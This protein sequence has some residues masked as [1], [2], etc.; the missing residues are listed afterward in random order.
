MLPVEE[1][2]ERAVITDILQEDFFVHT[3]IP[4][5]R[6]IDCGL[7]L[8]EIG[9][10]DAVRVRKEL[11]YDDMLEITVRLASAEPFAVDY[12]DGK[13]Y[14]TPFPHVLIKKP[15]VHHA[16]A[17]ELPRKAFFL[18]YHPESVA[19]LEQRGMSFEPLIWQISLTDSLMAILEK[20]LKISALIHQPMMREKADM[21]AWAF[22]LELLEFRRSDICNDERFR[23]FQEIASSL[24]IH[25]LKSPD[26]A[27]LAHQHGLSER[28]FYRYWNTYY[29][30]SPVAFINRLKLEYARN[31][32]VYSN[33]TIAEIAAKLGFSPIYFDRFF[34]RR[35]GKTPC[36]YRREMGG[37]IFSAGTR[38]AL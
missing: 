11:V 24:Q 19:V 6:T 27:R 21:L 2:R 7:P 8:K 20:L 25:Y 29:N 15:G 31:N 4:R 32:L 9:Y 10:L 38:T 17:M 22:L 28:S 26:I 14:E 30:E 16:Y 35:T 13:R 1:V 5:E 3:V 37:Q 34:K 36:C 18:Q 12:L 23:K 33:M